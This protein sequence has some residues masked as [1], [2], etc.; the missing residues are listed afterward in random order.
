MHKRDKITVQT[1]LCSK[2]QGE[3][4]GKKVSKRF[5]NY[6]SLPILQGCW[7]NWYIILLYICKIGVRIVHIYYTWSSKYLFRRNFKLNVLYPFPI[8]IHI[9]KSLPNIHRYGIYLYKKALK[10]NFLQ[11]QCFNFLVK[12]RATAYI[13]LNPIY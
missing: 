1:D 7:K 2:Q 4:K 5:Q 8:W 11:F 9:W 10:Q 6:Q 3:Q 13:S 12:S